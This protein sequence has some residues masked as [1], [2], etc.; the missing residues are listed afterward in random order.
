MKCDTIPEIIELDNFDGNYEKYEE[1]VYLS[2]KTTFEGQE[3][4]WGNKRIAHKKHPMYKEKPGTFWHIIS[5]GEDEANRIPDLR[6]YE[7]VAWPAHILGYCVHYCD[8]ILTWKNIR[9]G[10]TR[11]LIWCKEIEYLVVLDERKDFCIFWTAYPV[12]YRHTKEKLQKEYDEYVKQN[13]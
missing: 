1:A 3:F 4:F 11:I 12:T 2:Y 13:K 8:K 7:R 10:K 5:N 9:K 6:R